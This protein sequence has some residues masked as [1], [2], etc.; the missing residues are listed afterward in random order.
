RQVEGV[1]VRWL[2]SEK[3]G[4]TRYAMRVFEVDPGRTIPLHNHWQEQEMYVLEGTGTIS[5]GERKWEL[6]PN[7]VIF[8][9]P[10]EPHEIHNTG[11][12]VLCFIC[13]IPL[14]K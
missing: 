10:D 1:R 13:V 14:K 12:G 2:I 3:N 11:S 7:T 8:V 6:S 5:D 4:A 9:P